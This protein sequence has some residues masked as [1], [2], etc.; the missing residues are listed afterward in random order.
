MQ[1]GKEAGNSGR[2]MNE[3]AAAQ[4]GPLKCADGEYAKRQRTCS[5]Q[6]IEDRMMLKL[7]H[8]RTHSGHGAVHYFHVYMYSK[9]S[10]NQWTVPYS[11]VLNAR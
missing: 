9:V 11:T 10:R 8:F 2:G 7:G 5:R 1:L 4:N 3:S 6:S